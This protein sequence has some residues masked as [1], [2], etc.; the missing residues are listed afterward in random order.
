MKLMNVKCRTLMFA[1]IAGLLEKNTN[2]KFNK[3]NKLWK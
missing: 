1:T 3:S 2:I